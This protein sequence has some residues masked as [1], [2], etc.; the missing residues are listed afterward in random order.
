MAD[1]LLNAELLAACSALGYSDGIKYHKEADCLETTKDLVRYL[2]KDDDSHEIRRA[3]GD[4]RVVQTDLIPIVRDHSRDS[5][6]FDVTLRLLVNLTNPALLLFKEELPE[7]KV[8]RQQFLHL[9]SQQ[10]G[11]KE[12]FVEEGLWSVLVGKLGEL[13][14]LDWESRQEEDRLI[15]ERILILVRNILSVPASPEDEKR[16]EDD[17]SIH[18]QV[19]WALHLAGFEDLLL[20]IASSENEQELCMHA[21]EIISL[22]LR[23]QNPALLAKAGVQRSQLEKQRD[24]VELI[25]L[26][27]REALKKQQQRRKYYGARHSRFGGTYYVQN[28]KS[29]SERNLISHRAITDIKSINFDHGKKSRKQPK[30]RADMKDHISATR[31]STL[32]IRLFLQ[33]FSIEFLNGAYNSIM[34]TVKD[35]LD[36]AKS[37]EHDES[38]YLWAMKFFM[39]F[40]RHHEFKLELV[41]ETLSIQT[42][43]YIQTH[44]EKYYEMMT[45]DK[46]KIPLWSRRMHKA[47]RAYQELLMT[48]ACMDKSSSEE[49]RESSKVLKSKLFYVIEYRE[50]ILIL[51]QNYDRVKMSFAYLKDLVETAHIFL[52]L[53]EQF[54]SRS[55]H[56]VVMK[57]K[58]KTKKAPRVVNQGSS[59]P[60]EEQLVVQ[61]DEMSAE[62]SAVVQGEAG[63][64]PETI[65]FD[66]LSEDP[67]DLQKET[68]MRKINALL[69]QKNL[70]E[71]VSLLRSSRECWP[72]GDIF[73]AQNITP[74]EE[75]L[76][77]REIFMAS[78]NPIAE[79]VASILDEEEVDEEES[80]NYEDIREE[81]FD[82]TS[83]VRRFAHTRV[84]QAYA[85]LFQSYSTNSAHTNHCILKMFHRIAWDSK[86]PAMFF[87]ASLFSVFRKSM[88]D[89][90]KNSDSVKE[91]VKFAKYIV[92]EFFRT[93]ETNPKVFTELFF[94]KNNKEALEIMCGYEAGPI[95][96]EAAKRAW[97]EEEEDEL[98]RLFEEFKDTPRESL[99]SK[100]CVDLILENLIKQSRTRRGILKKLKDLGLIND[101]KELSG[102]KAVKVRAPK[103]W[104]EEEEGELRMLYEDNKDAMDI[105]GRIM[106]HMVIRRPKA[107]VIEKILELGLVADR[108]E[109]RKKKVKKPRRERDTSD[110]GARFNSTNEEAESD[111]ERRRR[112]RKWSDGESDEEIHDDWSDE[113]SDNAEPANEQSVRKPKPHI[114]LVATPGLVSKSLR[115][116][117]EANMKEAV[118]W[119]SGVLRDVA[120]D[121]EEDGDFEPVPILAMTET[122]IDAMENKQFQEL[123]KLIGLQPPLNNQE[124]FWRVPSRL[125]VEALRKRIQYLQQDLS[126]TSIAMESVDELLESIEE[127]K[128]EEKN[129]SKPTSSKK[130]LKK[131]KLAS[132][133]LEKKKSVDVDISHIKNENP[134]NKENYTDGYK[135]AHEGTE[136]APVFP[137]RSHVNDS[138]SSDEDLPLSRQVSNI[139]SSKSVFSSSKNNSELSTYRNNTSKK[140]RL[141]LN[142][143]DSDDDTSMFN[144]PSQDLNLHLDT[145]V[146]EKSTHSIR[147][148]NSDDDDDDNSQTLAKQRPKRIVE[149][150]IMA[151]KNVKSAIEIGVKHPRRITV[152]PKKE[153]IAK[154]E[155]GVRVSDLATQYNFTKSTIC[156]ILKNKEI[157]KA[158]DVA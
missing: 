86:L 106:D 15:I 142:D 64:L 125:S 40:N 23:E 5:E 55:R 24:E 97:S 158:A 126:G 131:Q 39:E 7:E 110:L 27:Q 153:I 74:S 19:L 35:N 96:R 155:N 51:L 11:Y 95:G 57:K 127:V 146:M 82:F 16:T 77:L 123:M 140:R 130:K 149:T 78:L 44:L 90:K 9:V 34:Y 116:V 99:E 37:Q 70:Q 89:P 109:L 83:F 61:W 129:T 4:T 156:T 134:N 68:A 151:L 28:M 84:M 36:R 6:L 137:K 17:A 152:E 38:Y 3:L 87:Q 138:E 12:A 67:E 31:R 21:L 62:V 76:S 58:K 30:N 92:R 26:R 18:D 101:S 88:H 32:A 100:D 111:E 117:I 42:F 114:P 143:E 107:R 54:C 136:S 8:T 122:C 29:I 53:L 141:I 72:E 41:S 13:L 63:D 69:R 148:V 115:A 20:Y 104:T 85:R 22:M 144:V 154:H 45:T 43:H 81:D 102:R 145:E 79:P 105:V 25:E 98:K 80:E 10:Q 48:L 2:R 108:A 71:A 132:S 46:K 133:D 150:L 75:F 56:L 118:E 113:D 47:L 91:M 73:G 124:M 66:T 93:V 94:W 52:K 120:D 135:S 33:E 119:L 112:T 65:P 128:D 121:R 14:Q 157:L 103:T 147:R 59:Q 60:T 50:M 49:V 139:L 1:A